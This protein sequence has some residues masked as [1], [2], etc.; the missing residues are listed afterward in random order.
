MDKRDANDDIHVVEEWKLVIHQTPQHRHINNA[1]LNMGQLHLGHRVANFLPD[2]SIE[3]QYLSLEQCFDHSK[4]YTLSFFSSDREVF[5]A[6]L[7]SISVPLWVE[8]ES[9]AFCC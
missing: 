6:F 1:G 4:P 5:V 2:A 9:L 8:D 7:I 3:D